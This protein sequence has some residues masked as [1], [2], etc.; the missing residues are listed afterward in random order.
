MRS[1]GPANAR[2]QT[3]M[4]SSRPPPRSIGPRRRAATLMQ[5]SLVK[6]SPS[7]SNGCPTEAASRSAITGFCVPNGIDTTRHRAQRPTLSVDP[8]VEA[9]PSR[10]WRFRSGLADVPWPVGPDDV[11]QHRLSAVRA[12]A[13]RAAVRS[14]RG[15]WRRRASLTRLDSSRRPV[16]GNPSRACRV[17]LVLA[18]GGIGAASVV[19]EHAFTRVD[20]GSQGHS[21]RCIA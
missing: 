16:Q 6:H 10:R 19:L 15:D 2:R 14:P 20:R 1:G 11:D 18:T 7:P 13:L 9:N 21:R 8:A 17:A 4:P 12:I 3:G 5:A